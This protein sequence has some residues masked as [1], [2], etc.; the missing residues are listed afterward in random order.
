M[1]PSPRPTERRRGEPWALGQV[2]GYATA[3]IL[4]RLAVAHADPLILP[5]LRGLPSLLLGILLVGKN[6]T[7]GQI[8]PHSPQY[9]GRRA[10][11]PFIWAGIIS[12][13]GLFAY[14]F[15]IRVGGVIITIPALETYVIWGPLIAWFALK[16]QLRPLALLGIGLIVVGL[17][18]L[19]WGQWRGQPATPY[20]YWAVPL[21]IFAAL[22]YGLSGVLWR[23]GQLRGAHQSTAILLQFLASIAVAIAGLGVF[24]RW[25]LLQ[26]AAWRDL[27]A[28]LAS[29]VFSGIIGIYCMFTALRLMSVARVYAF[30]ALTPLVAALFARFFLH[31]YLSLLMLAGT[32]LVSAGVVLTQVFRPQDERQ[33]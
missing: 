19:S 10:I 14:A 11:L 20:W 27:S 25:S 32:L 26:E 18:A 23:D 22:T 2:L 6:H 30:S 5:L 9:V 28:L 24:G 13:V 16:E 15:A 12:T 31:E 8:E 29:G 1:E 3:N 4:D 17:L 21:A 33:A 7:L